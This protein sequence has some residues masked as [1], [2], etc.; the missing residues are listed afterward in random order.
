MNHIDL[1]ILK[2]ELRDCLE[3]INEQMDALIKLDGKIPRIEFDIIL[4]NIRKMYETLQLLYRLNDPVEKKMSG[5][6]ISRTEH[7][8][9]PGK[10]DN[11]APPG[12]PEAPTLFTV[13]DL[14]FTQKLQEAREKSLGSGSN[15]K[16]KGDIKSLISIN[17]KFLFIN[18]LFDGNLRDYSQ[19]I[20]RLNGLKEKKEVHEFLEELLKKNFWDSQSQAFIK[21]CEIIEKRFA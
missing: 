14:S 2:A 15:D 17:E 9:P 10:T 12:T 20:D 4:E 6:Q 18:E 3:S 11:H 21:L 5:T 8:D 7:A 13:E 19:A 1:S 16:I